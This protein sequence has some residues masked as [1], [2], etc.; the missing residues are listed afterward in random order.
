MGGLWYLRKPFY[1]V[2]TTKHFV[3]TWIKPVRDRDSA[4]GRCIFHVLINVSRLPRRRSKEAPSS[5][6]EDNSA[7]LLGNYPRRTWPA[8]NTPASWVINAAAFTT[9]ECILRVI[10]R[11]GDSINSASTA[12]P[13]RIIYRRNSRFS[14]FHLTS[15][16]LISHLPAFSSSPARARRQKIIIMMKMRT[17]IWL[18]R[19]ECDVFVPDSS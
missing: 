15:S 10:N 2:E 4:A 14:L 6:S 8:K 18:R 7:R 9:R 11:T 16:Q 12:V 1:S 5:R 13:D 3:Q 19:V 17:P